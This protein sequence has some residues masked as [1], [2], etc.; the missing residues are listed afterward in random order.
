MNSKILKTLITERC[1]LSP[2]AETDFD[3]LTLLIGAEVRRYLGGAIPVERF[4]EQMRQSTRESNTLHF[5]VFIKNTNARIGLITVAPHHNPADTEISYM[6]LPEYWGNGYAR[7]SV[8]AALDFCGRELKLKRVVAETQTANL[9]SRNLLEKL[10]YHAESK[11]E[12]FGAEQTI[13]VY[14]F[15]NVN[16]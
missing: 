9:R 5:T 6:F 14:E 13:Y 10:G 1:K 4:L 3:E 12:R 2:L 7:E 11:I 15:A 8:K 16:S